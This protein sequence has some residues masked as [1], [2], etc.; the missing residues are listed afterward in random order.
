MP[1]PLRHGAFPYPALSVAEITS[2]VAASLRIERDWTNRIG[3]TTEPDFAT[4][5]FSSWMID[6]PMISHPWTRTRE[7]ALRYK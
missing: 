7:G 6:H 5:D 1:R 4:D 3:R 2:V